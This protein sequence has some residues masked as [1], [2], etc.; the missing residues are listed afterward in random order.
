[1]VRINLNYSIPHTIHLEFPLFNNL[2]ENQ[3]NQQ[4][5]EKNLLL[6][7]DVLS[8]E[9]YVLGCMCDSFGS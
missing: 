6:F 5:I 2:L 9:E 7:E 1:M 4:R 8:I 3:D